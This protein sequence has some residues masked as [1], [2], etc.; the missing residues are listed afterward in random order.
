MLRSNPNPKREW[1]F[2]N[3]N[4]L[5]I[6]KAEMKIKMLLKITR[7]LTVF[8]EHGIKRLICHND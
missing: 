2:F 8:G 4:A 6:L 1:N 7:A 3:E 5:K